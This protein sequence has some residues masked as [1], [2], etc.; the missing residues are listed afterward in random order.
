MITPPIYQ[1]VNEIEAIIDNPG[2]CD[3]RK[4]VEIRSAVRQYKTNRPAPVITMT[5]TRTELQEPRYNI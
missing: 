2:I 1:L 3:S 5:Q 4:Y